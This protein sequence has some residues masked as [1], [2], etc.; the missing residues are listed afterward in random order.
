MPN[1]ANDIGL[2][3]SQPSS[4]LVADPAAD[5]RRYHEAV[6]TA[7][8]RVLCS[9]RYILGKEVEA[10]ED[11]WARYLGARYCV[12]VAS[13]TDALA[14]AL[15]AV[16]IQTGDEV[17]TVSHTAVATVAAIESIGA[18]PVFV[19]ID[20]LSR[21]MD[22][23]LLEAILSSSTRAVVPVHVYGQPADMESI[24]TITRR[25]DLHVIEDCAQAHGAEIAGRKVGTFGSAAAFSFYPTKNLGAVGDA[26]AVVCNDATIAAQI[27][28]LRQYG[29]HERYISDIVGTNSR[30]D[31]LQAAILRVKLPHL[32]Q[33]NHK[34]RIIADRYRQAL[35]AAGVSGPSDIEGTTHAMHLFVVES[36][37]RDRLA[38]HLS[39]VGIV[40]ALHYPMPVHR[41]PAYAGRIRGGDELPATEALYKRLLTIPCHPDLTD[42]QVERICDRLQTWSELP[43]LANS[44]VSLSEQR[45]ST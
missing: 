38:D 10:F 13:G 36:Q 15:K 11:E 9:G 4:I 21:C 7:V 24:L 22:P 6:L 19:D 5:V 1:M 42:D 16:G 45:I 8:D 18:R 41:Q 28:T 27:R 33:R 3:P 37:M 34:R 44:P 12:G 29:W 31:E 35:A 39:Q 2:Q 23:R 20:P 30:L 14:L 32:D 43:S 25:Y 26:G 17:V 40:T